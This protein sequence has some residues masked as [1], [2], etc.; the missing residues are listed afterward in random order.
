MM[1]IR[2]RKRGSTLPS[3]KHRL[4]PH[5]DTHIAVSIK[6]SRGSKR[7]KDIYARQPLM[8]LPFYLL[9]LS[10]EKN[11]IDNKK[12]Y[13]FF[14]IAVQLLLTM[15]ANTVSNKRAQLIVFNE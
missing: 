15:Y 1:G 3:L 4:H 14:I 6:R 9:M 8:K 5:T 13:Q 10:K 11:R 7:N 12:F 2:I